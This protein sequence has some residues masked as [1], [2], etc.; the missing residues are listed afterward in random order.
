MGDSIGPGARVRRSCNHKVGGRGRGVPRAES[1][2][3]PGQEFGDEREP[4]RRRRQA[5]PKRRKIGQR[6]RA[7][8]TVEEV[9]GVERSVAKGGNSRVMPSPGELSKRALDERKL[10]G[11]LMGADGA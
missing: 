5:A 11:E 7:R 1:A 8:A 9:F 3:D 4:L 6:R 10:L 2:S